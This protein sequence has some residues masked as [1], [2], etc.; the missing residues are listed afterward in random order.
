M[1]GTWPRARQ[2]RDVVTQE[3]REIGQA[4]LEV[5]LTW[6]EDFLSC[7]SEMGILTG[8]ISFSSLED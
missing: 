4:W 8:L 6:L 7:I 5:R 2:P 3:Q 1:A